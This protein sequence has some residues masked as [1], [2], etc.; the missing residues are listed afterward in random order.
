[1][2]NQVNSEI[3]R[4]DGRIQSVEIGEGAKGSPSMEEASQIGS[5]VFVI[6]CCEKHQIIQYAANSEL[7]LII[8]PLKQVLV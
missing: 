1:M 8:C 3:E 5:E 7:P 4:V 2:D 6:P